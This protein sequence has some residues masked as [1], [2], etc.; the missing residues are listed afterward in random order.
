MGLPSQTKIL[1][2]LKTLPPLLSKRVACFIVGPQ[3]TVWKI[4]SLDWL[5][6]L[7]EAKAEYAKMP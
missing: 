5:T 3:T 2:N 1:N 6:F 4:P 7:R